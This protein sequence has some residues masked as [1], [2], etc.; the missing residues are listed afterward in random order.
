MKFIVRDLIRNAVAYEGASEEF[1]RGTATHLVYT[2]VVEV[3]NDSGALVRK[4][5]PEVVFRN[6]E[7]L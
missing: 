6:E 2:S 3:Y 7:V 5:H 4:M 1:A